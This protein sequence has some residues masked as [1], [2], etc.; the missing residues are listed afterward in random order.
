MVGACSRGECRISNCS[1][2]SGVEEGNVMESDEISTAM[3]SDSGVARIRELQ[4]FLF[5]KAEKGGCCQG[6]PNRLT[7][8]GCPFSMLVHGWPRHDSH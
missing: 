6:S 1:F 7:D 3:P 5:G 2:Q 8:S 4:W